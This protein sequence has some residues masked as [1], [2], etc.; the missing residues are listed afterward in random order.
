MS[1]VWRGRVIDWKEPKSWMPIVSRWVR[2]FLNERGIRHL[3]RMGE[4]DICWDDSDWLKK[5]QTVLQFE[6]EYVVDTLADALSFAAARTFH[7]CRTDD[8]GTYRRIGIR[9]NDPAVLA[10]E[11]RRIVSEEDQLAY[12]RPAIE[13]R[14]RDFDS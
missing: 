13:Q 3:Q 11:V 10:D 9:R 2:P 5:T 12:L 14:L 6:V 8:A 4:Q 1:A 7:G